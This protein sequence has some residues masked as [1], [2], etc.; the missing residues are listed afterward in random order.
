MLAATLPC[1]LPAAAGAR[2][3]DP[4]IL[5]HQPSDGSVVKNA[6]HGFDVEFA[7]PAYHPYRDDDVL[8]GPVD[9]YHVILASAP[10]VNKHGLL[11]RRNWVDER[12]GV[13][14]DQPIPL[15]GDSPP[16]LCTAAK[17]DA[18][19]G[20]RPTEPGRYWWQV[21]RDCASSACHGAVDVSFPALVSAVRTPCNVNRYL[22]KRA[23]RRLRAARYWLKRR[24]SRRRHR[25]VE[26]LT[27]R[28]LVLHQ[29]TRIV[30]RC[31][32]HR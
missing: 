22:L 26:H 30:Y 17:D 3:D 27:D 11:L 20:L 21:Y 25:R 32:R 18:G 5:L 24:P 7:C 29:R 15:S 10:A 31:R 13:G 28:V 19:D 12:A 1:L 16:P 14:I 9:G 4:P 6:L 2:S 23:T 8:R